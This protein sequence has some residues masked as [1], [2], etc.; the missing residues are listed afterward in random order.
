MLEAAGWS[1]QDMKSF[2]PTAATGVAVREFPLSS[3][4]ADYLLFVDRRAVGVIEAKKA[5]VPLSGVEAQSERYTG[6]L[7]EWVRRVDDPLP[8]VYESTG[9]ETRFRDARDPEFRS[10]R[11]FWFHKPRTLDAWSRESVTLRARLREMPPLATAGLRECQVEAI[12]GLERS[13]A[14][15]RPRA[16]IQMATGSGKTYTAVSAV[17]RLIKHAGARRVLF[18]V[19]RANLGRQTLKEF[20]QYATPDDGRK[21][22]ELYN[23]TQLAGRNV[24]PVNKVC[25]STIQR[26]FSILRGEEMDEEL[27]ES[28]LNEL[29][30][31]G[32]REKEVSYNSR[33]PVETFDFIVVD[34]CHRSI[35]NVW[36]QVLE[37]FD[38]TLIGL[39][40]TPSK[41]TLGF[42]NNNLV[43]EYG[44][45]RAVA[46]GVNVGYDVYRIKTEI[47][48]LGGRIDAGFY[49]DYRDKATR[50]VRWQR[51]DE[52]LEFTARELDR[53]VVARDQIRTVVR[54]YRDRLP[55]DLFPGREG[56]PKTLVFAKDD[57][58][59]ED[60]VEVV[61]EEFGKGNEFCKKITYRTAEKPE[62]LINSF[63][64]SPMPR[65]AVTVDMI[66][67][68][69]DVK[70]LEVLIFMRDVK[71]QHY[72]EQMVGRGTRTISE[73][74]L[75]A[76][77][78]GATRKTHFVLVDAV[79]VSESAKG[80]D[81]RPL[82]KKPGVAFE[83]LLKRVAFGGADADA[84]TSLASRL[85]R[86]DRTL[87]EK[88]RAGIRA[89]SGGKEVPEL[90]NGLL[91]AADPDAHAERAKADHGTDSPTEAELREA[92]R[93]MADEATR[94]FGSPAL[95][96]ALARTKK[97]NEQVIDTV[98]E[99]RVLY[100]GYDYDRAGQMVT[101]FEKF[102]EENRDELLALQIIF[103]RPYGERRLTLAAVRELAEALERPPRHLYAENL[104]R[105]Y[106][107]LE[108]AKVKGASS[109]KLLTNII[110][111]VRFAG[112]ESE[113]LEPYPEG[114]ERR[115]EAWLS[116]Q[117]DRFGAEQIEWL[118]MIKDHVSTSLTIEPEDLGEAPFSRKGGKLK[119]RKLFGPELPKLLDELNEALAA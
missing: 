36:R 97:R 91:S 39:T 58:H 106:E 62:E 105:A 20:Q 10:R 63:R 6:G 17:Y 112:G 71:S 73:T 78:P 76:V 60:I 13:L 84:L 30:S 83:E 104:W 61:R 54:T 21:F 110:S 31:A 18:L 85:S 22:T 98:S 8:F 107:R 1:V 108:K 23:V 9:T 40:A 111:L 7:P 59:A 37:Y 92:A 42:F 38:A 70:P 96:E 25:I 29:A 65:I 103:S 45:E 82:E 3:G 93:A 109:E 41:Q 34:E 74:D 57:T 79:G 52:E 116:G 5:G 102:I 100:A 81:V 35:Y 90:A 33:V 55:M 66:S 118:T 26:M 114:V 4:F 51:L 48:E 43:M 27:D 77:V 67:T 44:H 68:G 80:T 11:V 16:L 49:V 15:N 2:D 53:S 72:Y 101:D 24:D 95:R 12:S 64:N 69:T 88:D 14:E 89:A 115:F 32:E 28:S 46:D 113:V 86:L 94:P 87:D 19:D 119:A 117:G 75:K 56:V 99:D 50:E 47:G